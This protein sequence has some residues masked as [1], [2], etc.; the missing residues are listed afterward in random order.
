MIE[1]FTERLLI[2][3]CSLDIAKSLIFHRQELE[4]RSPIIIPQGW[5]SPLVKS[6]LPIYIENLE[7][8]ES[9]YGWGLWMI[10]DYSEKKIIGDVYLQGKPDKR[11]HVNI[12][13]NMVKDL[14]D[15]SLTYEAVD[16]L[17]EWL[18]TQTEATKVITECSDSN[19]QYIRLFEKLGMKCT[20]K[21]GK[22]LMWE[23]SEAM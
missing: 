2:V 18:I 17:I 7:E 20:K 21:E 8:D 3:P 23:L 4:K 11:G 13:F 16:A 5:P 10:I 12:T 1:I 22:F 15:Y 19:L 6:T 14:K 9:V